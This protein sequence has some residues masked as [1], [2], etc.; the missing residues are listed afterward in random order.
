MPDWNPS[1][2]DLLGN[3]W[4]ATTGEA[5][6]VWHG[7]APRMMRGPVSTVTETVTSLKMWAELNTLMRADA[8]T[9]IDVIEEGREV[10]PL[11]TITS[12]KP[13]HDI[14]VGSWRNR[15]TGA[16]TN[17]FAVLDS[18]PEQWPGP[19]QFEGIHN[20]T[21]AND[22]YECA[23]DAGSFAVGGSMKNAR[24]GFVQIRAILGT[25]INTRKLRV[26]LVIDGVAYQPSGGALR[27]VTGFGAIYT[28]QY[29]ELNPATQK[30]WTPADIAK[31]ATGGGSK[32]RVTSQALTA[33]QYPVVAALAL[34]A[35][36]I[37]VEN[38]AAV[39]VWRRPIVA[40]DRLTQVT[41]DSLM[42]YP[43]GAANWSKVA[44]KSYLYY[45][46]HSVSPS[47]YGPIVADD[48]RWLGLY[49]ELG[50][51]GKPPGITFPLDRT[52][53]LR[54]HGPPGVMANDIVGH[55]WFGR[56]SD[57]FDANYQAGYSI[58]P[59]VG[60]TASVDSQPYRGDIV[61]LVQLRNDQRVGQ[62]VVPATTQSY[63][64]VRFPVVPLGTAGNATVTVAVHRVSDGVQMGGTFTITLAAI[65]AKK[66]SSNGWR[67]VD[68]FLSAAAALTA[69]TEYEIRFTV[70]PLPAGVSLNM[71]APSGEL[72][73]AAMFGGG[74]QGLVVGSTHIPTRTLT[75][76][77]IRQP[78]PVTAVTPTV[79]NVPITTFAA[80]ATTVAHVQVSWTKPATSLGLL[81]GEYRVERQ[82]DG[83]EW[84]HVCTVRDEPVTSWLDR[85]VERNGAARYR[86]TVLATDGRISATVTSAGTATPTASGS[87][88]VLTSNHRTDL[89]IV[90]IYDRESSYP[91][92]SSEKNE[93]VT[94]HGTD[95]QVVFTEH[96][97][98]GVGWRTKVTVSQVTAAG[99]GGRARFERLLALE[100]ALD[101]PYVCAM[102]N[103]GMKIFGHLTVSDAGLAQPQH[104]YTAAIEMIPTRVEP[105]PVVV[106]AT[107][108]QD[109]T[110]LAV[111]VVG[112]QG[113]LAE[114]QQDQVSVAEGAA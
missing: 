27:N 10:T 80:E 35:Y 5:S 30:P 9:V 3:E 56:P 38:R 36:T 67:Y 91:I 28:L 46:R 77:L 20:K 58:V 23:V 48:I 114:T 64:G 101:I 19:A 62:R 111:G 112:A 44:G 17:L 32:I 15:F 100:G 1:F 107:P 45:W 51:G 39:G 88:V 2:P 90:H 16:A 94:L 54:L 14:R 71:I 76:N 50:P 82:V 6:R 110:L 49:Q 60:A 29:G 37:P 70:T 11:F 59:M 40:A 52:G 21:T 113:S 84:F 31:F 79:V 74:T 73:P 41:T 43:S 108:Q 33:T 42:T 53:A 98:R 63:I 7:A 18:D 103:L 104:R 105:E 69:A 26:E 97:D 8:R 96:E 55:D 13:T 102:D 78:D 65:R 61:D 34:Q 95:L 93:V 81:F 4:F 72:G 12:M 99:K 47:L 24:I 106:D 66:A 89:E 87:L 83:G 86:I 75:V 22:A 85:E 92:L 57:R 25:N 68:G 109:Q